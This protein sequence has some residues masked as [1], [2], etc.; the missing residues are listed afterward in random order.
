[1]ARLCVAWEQAAAAMSSERTTV[2]C[3]RSAMVLDAKAGPLPRMALPFRLGAG[4]RLGDGTQY[5]SWIHRD[6]WVRLVRHLLQ[7]QELTGAFNA[8]APEPVRNADFAKTLA[9]VLARPAVVPTPAAALRLALGEMADALLLSSQRVIPAR[10]TSEGF[11]FTYPTL[12]AA[13]R[14]IYGRA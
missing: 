4:G 14:Q 8:A 5:T 13:L 3:I 11:A 6:D 7:R 9:Q 12:H 10:A 2:A 1:L